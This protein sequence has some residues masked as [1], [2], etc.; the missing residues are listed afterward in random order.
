VCDQDHVVALW[1]LT[2]VEVVSA[3]RRL[4]RER[5]IDEHHARLAEDRM[6]AIARPG[7]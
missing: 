2:P 7:T 1:T 3:V 5:A 6:Q 4:V